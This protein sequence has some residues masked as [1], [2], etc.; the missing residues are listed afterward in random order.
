MICPNCG[1]EKAPVLIRARKRDDW[2]RMCP[3]CGHEE[4]LGGEKDG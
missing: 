1:S 3:D 4:K 2:K